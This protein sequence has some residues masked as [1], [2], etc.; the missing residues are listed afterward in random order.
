MAITYHAGRRVQAV[1]TD[2]TA[3]PTVAGGWV[4]LGRTTLGSAGDTLAVSSFSNKRYYMVLYN[5]GVSTEL[6]QYTTFGSGGTADT[7]SN[8]S[9]RISDNGNADSTFTSRANMVSGAQSGAT[10]PEFGVGYISNLAAKEKLWIHHAV[11]ENTAGAGTAPVRAEVTGKWANTSNALDVVS[12]NNF[13]SGDFPIGSEAVVLGWDPADTHTSNFWEELASVDL[14]GGAADTLSSGTFTAKK[15]LWIQA[16][17]TATGG[18]TNPYFR[19]GNT[20]LD[21]GSNYA[22]RY[23][24]NGAADSTLTS[25]SNIPLDGVTLATGESSFSNFFIINNASNEKLI[26]HHSVESEAA[27]A[28]AAPSRI[29]LASK[30][31]NTSNQID[32]V[33][34]NNVSGTG[35]F[36]TKTT[37]KV[38]GSD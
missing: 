37:L 30:W 33:G 6:T 28:G 2:F 15:Y 31:T 14:S 20:T 9:N 13:G 19:V 1:S 7:G 3:S 12:F 36:G 8:Y 34:L 24:T 29:E 5:S 10:R 26:I 4:E 21:T 16:Y 22:I 35:D 25:Q 32:I 17:T 18:T 11:N 27:G 38:W 23:S